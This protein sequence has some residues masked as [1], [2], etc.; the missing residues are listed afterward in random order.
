M[1]RG[2][3]FLDNYCLPL[4]H[5]PHSRAGKR[6]CRHIQTQFAG[7][8]LHIFAAMTK[9]LHAA[10]EACIYIH[11]RLVNT[12]NSFVTISLKFFA[13]ELALAGFA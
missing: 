10:I 6:N 1:D 12:I 13:V 8:P 7:C 5:F 2:L 4:L 3:K 11:M 9:R